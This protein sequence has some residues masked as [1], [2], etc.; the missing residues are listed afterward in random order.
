MIPMYL[1]LYIFGSSVVTIHYQ[2]PNPTIVRSS[3]HA[4]VLFFLPAVTFLVHV[5]FPKITLIFRFSLPPTEANIEA[6]KEEVEMREKILTNHLKE[7]INNLNQLEE[8]FGQEDK[9]LEE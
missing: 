4:C 1:Y 5:L 6:Q 2:N 7:I 9:G 3:L 8:K